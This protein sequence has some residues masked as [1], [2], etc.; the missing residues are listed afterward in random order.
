MAMTIMEML[1]GETP[2]GGKFGGINETLKPIFR[3]VQKHMA[4]IEEARSRNYSWA[5]IEEVC[6]ELWESSKDAKKF[7]WWKKSLLIA[8]CYYA[9]KKGMTTTHNRVKC[10]DKPAKKYRI[11][12][13]AEE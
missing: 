11:Q 7:V 8:S 3:F 6:R 12:V 4:E 13:T 10:K 5:Q 2:R 1:K 9:L